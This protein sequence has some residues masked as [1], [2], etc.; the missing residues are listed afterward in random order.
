MSMEC[1][2]H[3]ALT[4]RHAHSDKSLAGNRAEDRL[5]EIGTV[6]RIILKRIEMGCESEKWM[7]LATVALVI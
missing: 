2:G 7:H 6:G 1:A 4:T 5:L 3:V